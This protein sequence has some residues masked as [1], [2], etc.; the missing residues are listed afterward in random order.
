M[1]APGTAS[2]IAAALTL[3]IILVVSYMVVSLHGAR[4]FHSI[5]DKF[6][7]WPR[8]PVLAAPKTMWGCC[9]RGKT[10][11][12]MPGIEFPEYQRP[13]CGVLGIPP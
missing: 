9:P 7:S 6:R 4:R 10:T 2:L 13:C 5:T 1:A 11:G 3:L 8:F 12:V